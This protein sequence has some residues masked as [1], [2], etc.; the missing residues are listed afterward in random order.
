[1]SGDDHMVLAAGIGWESSLLQC[2]AVDKF[3]CPMFDLQRLCFVVEMQ[4][5]QMIFQ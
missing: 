5:L 3:E 1:M 4:A 2:Q